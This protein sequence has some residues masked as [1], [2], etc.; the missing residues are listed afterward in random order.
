MRGYIFF[1]PDGFGLRLASDSGWLRTPFGLGLR[2]ASDLS[3]WF[4]W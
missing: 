3:E 2:M 1:Y 4:R